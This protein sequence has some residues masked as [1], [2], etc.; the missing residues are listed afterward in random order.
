MR[1]G[2]PTAPFDSLRDYV[3]ALE[4]R[5]LLLRFRGVDQDAY[6]ATG[7]MYA[8]I[9]EFGMHESPAV[10]F[11]DIRANGRVFPGPVVANTQGHM[12]T[13]AILFRDR[14][15]PAGRHAVLPRSPEDAAASSS[16]AALAP[17]R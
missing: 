15:A 1:R 5:G 12:D 7:I 3:A 9:E 16:S 2:G 14:A 10:L 4:A 17:T 11:E 6:E 13:E 8:L